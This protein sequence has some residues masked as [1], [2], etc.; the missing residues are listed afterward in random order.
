MDCEACKKN[1]C[2]KH[3]YSGHVVGVM[4]EDALHVKEE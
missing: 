2:C 3:S 1:L 4:T